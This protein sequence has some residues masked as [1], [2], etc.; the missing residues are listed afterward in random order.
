MKKLAIIPARMG[1]KGLKDK[2]IKDLCGKPMMAYTIEAALE[3]RCFDEVMVSTDSPQ[4]AEIAK[5]YGAAIPFLR[6]PINASDFATSWDMVKE[7]LE[8]YKSMGKFFDCFCLLQPTSPLRNS[9]DIKRAFEVLESHNADF[10]ISVC[11]MEHPLSWCGCLGENFS[12]DGFIQRVGQGTRQQQDETYRLNGAI[13]IVR[14][15]PFFEDDFIY[16]ENSYAY[17]MDK[18]RSID[19]DS[20][21]DFDLAEGL[22]RKGC[23]YSV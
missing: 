1:S 22:L 14:V 4:Y 18:D 2:N 17:I 6:N 13:Y 11:K 15:A 8:N 23:D 12:M 16:R 5:S 21:Y 20:Q 19:I 3:S 7:V 10:V 9:E